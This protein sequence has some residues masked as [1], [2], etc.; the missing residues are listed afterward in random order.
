MIKNPMGVNILIK[1][2]MNIGGSYARESPWHSLG[3]TP[4]IV[5]LWHRLGM[6]KIV[7]LPNRAKDLWRSLGSSSP[8]SGKPWH[9]LGVG[10]PDAIPWYSLGSIQD[11]LTMANS[12]YSLESSQLTFTNPWYSLGVS[13][14]HGVK[15]LWHSLGSNPMGSAKYLWY[16]LGSSRRMPNMWCRLEVS[17]CRVKSSQVVES[18]PP[19]NCKLWHS[20]GMG[21]RT[22]A[23]R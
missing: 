20:L 14:N 8:T 23:L 1:M 9:S 5:N 11:L 7:S 19:I 3:S 2:A 12:W 10:G 17:H 16:I 4:P 13:P 18:S 15:Y 22:P 21:P 6:G